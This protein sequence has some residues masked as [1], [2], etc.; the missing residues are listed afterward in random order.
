[1]VRRE[2]GGHVKDRP[3]GVHRDVRS[4]TRPTGRPDFSDNPLD[5]GIRPESNTCSGDPG[6]VAEGEVNQQTRRAVLI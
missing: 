4:G 3:S 6:E 2:V 1:M 5:T